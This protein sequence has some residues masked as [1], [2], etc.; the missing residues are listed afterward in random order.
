MV[1][2]E[3]VAHMA[4]CQ[5]AS[6]ARRSHL[7]NFLVSVGGVGGGRGLLELSSRWWRGE[8]GRGSRRPVWAW[9]GAC[10]GGGPLPVPAI[11]K[12]AASRP[13]ILEELLNLLVEVFSFFRFCYTETKKRSG[14]GVN[15]EQEGRQE[16]NTNRTQTKPTKSPRHFPIWHFCKSLEKQ[17]ADVS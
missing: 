16:Q 4:L 15:M 6:A 2:P 7:M 8:L 14:T 17:N 12:P 11:P 1:G 9:G 13:Q 3:V 5:M 10:W